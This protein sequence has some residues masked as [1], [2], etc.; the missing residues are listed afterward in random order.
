MVWLFVGLAGGAIIGCILMKI[1]SHPHPVGNLRIDN[2]DPDDG[3]YLFLEL[4][5]ES[6]PDILKL[7]KYVTFEVKAKD[8]ISHK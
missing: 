8:Y 1:L 2:S 7:K 5:S 3:P 4:S 6:T